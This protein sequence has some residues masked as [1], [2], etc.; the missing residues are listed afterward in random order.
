MICVAF[1]G[2]WGLLAGWEHVDIQP[3]EDCSR[4][5]AIGHEA[6]LAGCFR[7]KNAP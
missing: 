6:R 3:L 1:L 7:L 4:P 5:G 2:G